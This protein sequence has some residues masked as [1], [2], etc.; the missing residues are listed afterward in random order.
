MKT[1]LRVKQILVSLIIMS[2]TALLS[3]AQSNLAFYN[4]ND[5][6]NSPSFNPAYLNNQHKFTFSI[7]PLSGMSVGYSNQEVVNGM[8]IDLISGDLTKEK[9]SDIFESLLEKDLFSQRF[10]VSLLSFGYHSSL[11]AFNFRINEVEQ[12]RSGLKS[13]FNDFIYHPDFK[14]IRLNQPQNLYAS[15]VHYR[16]YSLGYA[17]EIIEKKL[18]IGLRAKIY[19][20]KASLL[21]DAQGQVTGNNGRYFLQTN[22]SLNISVPLVLDWTPKDSI[23][24]GATMPDNFK[25]ADYLFNN[26]NLGAGID[27]GFTYKVNQKVQISASVNDLGKINWDSNLNVIHLK[28]KCEIL[29]D[30][31]QPPEPGD[32]FITKSPAFLIESRDLNLLFTSVIDTTSTYSTRL[33]TSFFAGMQYQMNSILQI[34]VVDRFV[35]SKGMNQNSL[36]LTANYEVNKKLTIISGYSSIGKSYNNIPFAILYNWS[37]GQTYLGTDNLMAF[38][39]PSI[40]DFAGFSFGTCFYLF[41]PKVKYRESEYL[42]FYKEKKHNK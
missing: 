21:S 28:G 17:R 24:R 38:V 13:D 35:Q 1:V 31:I 20:G 9:M 26:Q 30:N 41:K 7:F 18:T 14:T 8:L 37:S 2:F 10:E 4:S 32:D 19:F 5:Q 22:N 27:L 23:I 16:E 40:A 25:P 34:G 12:L 39:L 33:P 15:G 36:S 6:F 42:P 3:N 29:P 11:G